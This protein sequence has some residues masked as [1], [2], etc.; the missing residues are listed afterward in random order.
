MIDYIAD[1]INK[2]TD[3]SIVLT[4]YALGR[5]NDRKQVAQGVGNLVESSTGL[6]AGTVFGIMVGAG[7]I[8]TA[9]SIPPIVPA[10][11]AVGFALTPV[12]ASTAGKVT[13]VGTEILLDQI[14]KK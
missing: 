5:E 6:A 7:T 9:S 10:I 11:G 1:S 3:S 4:N 14:A 2:F 8:A 13:E 12:I